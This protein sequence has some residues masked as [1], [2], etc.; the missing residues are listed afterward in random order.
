VGHQ[1]RHGYDVGMHEAA[2]TRMSTI[3]NP[4]RNGRVTRAANNCHVVTAVVESKI[5]D[6]DFGKVESPVIS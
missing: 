3:C 5:R 2:V 6:D 1:C 4:H